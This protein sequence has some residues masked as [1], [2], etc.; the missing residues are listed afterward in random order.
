MNSAPKIFLLF[1]VFTSA[2]SSLLIP[3]QKNPQF[4][5]N[6]RS[7]SSSL[8]TIPSSDLLSGT[9]TGEVQIG[10]PSQN[11]QILFDTGFSDLLVY[12]KECTTCNTSYLYNSTASNSS[13]DQLNSISF[14]YQTNNTIEAELF[15]DTVSIVGY[16]IPQAEFLVS[17]ELL[18]TNFPN[19]IFGLGLPSSS[20]G[21]LT[22]I[23]QLVAIQ[24]NLPQQFAIYLSPSISGSSILF[25]G[26][27]A[28]IAPNGFNNYNISSSSAWQVDVADFGLG[29]QSYINGATDIKVIMASGTPAIVGAP[30]LFTNLL[31]G[32]AASIPCSQT[33]NY[34]NLYIKLGNTTYEIPPTAYYLN[35]GTVNCTLLIV[36]GE[37]AG[38]DV[39][40]GQ[41]WL[42]VPFFESYYV[43]FDVQNQLVGIA[44]PTQPS[45]PTPLYSERNNGVY[46]VACMVL[47][48]IYMMI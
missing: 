30:G 15:D 12:S 9:Y 14:Q 2:V 22:S 23:F 42:G 32:L 17:K 19:G 21:N 20:L 8:T 11:F 40:A 38:Y 25:G 31:A 10:T 5:P 45:P 27:D 13:A 41:I 18:S 47:S 7:L 33:T 16:V 39:P 6:R 44:S 34:Q 35:I 29:T 26:Y 37:S 3:L 1:A 48:L 43:M 4:Q 24:Q 46:V 28:S 36:D